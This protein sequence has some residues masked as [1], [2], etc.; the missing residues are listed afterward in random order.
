MGLTISTGKASKNS[1]AKMIRGMS[2]ELRLVLDKLPSLY[3]FF[4]SDYTLEKLCF[5]RVNKANQDLIEKRYD[6]AALA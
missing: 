5:S 1:L 2:N 4:S 6:F 3:N